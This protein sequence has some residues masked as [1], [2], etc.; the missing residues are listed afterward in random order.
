MSRILHVIRTQW[1]CLTIYRLKSLTNLSESAVGT[2][3][4]N[5]L[6]LNL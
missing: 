1:V 3:M 6:H 2:R 4:F 5:K